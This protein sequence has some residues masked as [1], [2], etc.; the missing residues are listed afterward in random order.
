MV[1]ECSLTQSLSSYKN[2]QVCAT[3]KPDA[4]KVHNSCCDAFA[5]TAKRECTEKN[6]WLEAD[7]FNCTSDNFTRL[8]GQVRRHLAGV[9]DRDR[10]MSVVL[11]I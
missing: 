11:V 9:G 1:A 6:S 10:L 3:Q 5:G 7:L 4:G 2:L 8:Q